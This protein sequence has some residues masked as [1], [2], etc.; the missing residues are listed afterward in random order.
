MRYRSRSKRSGC[1][2]DYLWERTP[3]CH[4]HDHKNKRPDREGRKDQAQ[5][6]HGPEVIDETRGQN[7]LD[8]IR[9]VESQLQHHRVN[10]GD[11]GGGQGD[12]R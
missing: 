9:L 1:S 7:G 12:T 3:D 10:D 4:T 8:E 5:R 6:N 11:R 2:S